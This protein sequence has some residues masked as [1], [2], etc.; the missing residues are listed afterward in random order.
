MA[1]GLGR[2]ARTTESASGWVFDGWWRGD[3]VAVYAA[4][5]RVV[6]AR[7]SGFTADW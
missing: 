2:R 1:R 4:S 3:S 6:A 5:L 7:G